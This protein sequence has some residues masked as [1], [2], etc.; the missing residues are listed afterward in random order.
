MI[1]VVGEAMAVKLKNPKNTIYQVDGNMH[2]IVKQV[3]Y[4]HSLSLI[5]TKLRVYSV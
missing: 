5:M 2:M 1:K 4:F 3:I